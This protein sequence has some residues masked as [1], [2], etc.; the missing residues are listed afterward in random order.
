MSITNGEKVQSYSD[1]NLKNLQRSHNA[2][3]DEVSCKQTKHRRMSNNN[4]YYNNN[5]ELNDKIQLSW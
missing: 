1:S 2:E 4:N 3:T 5:K